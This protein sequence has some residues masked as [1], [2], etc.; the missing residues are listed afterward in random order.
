VNNEG[1]QFEDFSSISGLDSDADGRAVGLWD[2]DHDGWQDIAMVNSN[3]PLLNIFRNQTG[4]RETVKGKFIAVRLHGGSREAKPTEEWSN[5]DGFGAEITATC[6]DRKYVREHRCGEG[7]SAQ[8]SQTIIIGISNAEEVDSIQVRWP[9]GKTQNV[10]AIPAGKLVS[11]YENPDHA[12]TPNGHQI[13]PYE[14]IKSSFTEP[15]R[16]VNFELQDDQVAKNGA[17]KYRLYLATTTWC[18]SCKKAIPK[19]T[20]IKE[21]LGDKVAFYGVPVDQRDDKPKLEKYISEHK[22]PYKMLSDL[23]NEDYRKVVATFI[24]SIGHQALP[25]AYVVDAEGKIVGATAGVPTLSWLEKVINL[26]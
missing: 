13:L 12:P 17:N 24:S 7:F 21:K 22:P 4:A 18:D 16:F 25:S 1:K 3:A 19:L 8:N 6:G 23:P 14:A 26:E 15:E 2:F 9:S 20:K 11:I 10:G 5:R